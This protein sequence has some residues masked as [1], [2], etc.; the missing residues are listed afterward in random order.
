MSLIWMT[1][2]SGSVK[3]TIAK[4]LQ[5]HNQAPILDGD[6]VRQRL[7][8]GDIHGV[9]GQEQ[10]LRAVIT[11]AQELLAEHSYVI[12]AFV[13]PK[14]ELRQRVQAEV[15]ARGYQFLLIHV[16]TPLEI[17]KKRDPKGLYKRLEQG[18]DIK[19]AGVNVPYDLPEH[20][21]LS[22]NTVDDTPEQCA[23][24]ILQQL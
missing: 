15:E 11:L 4:A 12:A 9:E 23:E 22:C 21:A 20:P 18:D 14:K 19:L 8:K 2:Y 16:S 10:N 5:V 6:Q 17:C 13:S 24:K 1:G 3:T 7:A